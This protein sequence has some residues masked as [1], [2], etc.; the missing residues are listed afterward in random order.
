MKNRIKWLGEDIASFLT[1][2]H[3]HAE[4]VEKLRQVQEK[5]EIIS[6]IGDNR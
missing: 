5:C 1:Q 3:N 2:E 6:Q 4:L